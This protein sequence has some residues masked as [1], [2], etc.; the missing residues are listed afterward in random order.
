MVWCRISLDFFFFLFFPSD[1]HQRSLPISSEKTQTLLSRRP[2][3][4]E[5][6]A[7]L[8]MEPDYRDLTSDILHI[9]LASVPPP[10]SASQTVSLFY[11]QSD[12]FS[13]VAKA[14]QRNH[15]GTTEEDNEEVG[16]VWLLRHFCQS[17]RAALVS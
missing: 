10:R 9:C 16:E 5:V 8:Q 6:T 13:V 11:N 3:R 12:S 2:A 17:W 7:N 15:R 4:R 14:E 1:R